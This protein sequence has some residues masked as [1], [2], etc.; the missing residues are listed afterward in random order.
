[1]IVIVYRAEK[2]KNK[3]DRGRKNRR[4]NVDNF[5]GARRERERDD[6]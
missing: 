2:R 3:E 6:D 1:L 4:R 5:Y